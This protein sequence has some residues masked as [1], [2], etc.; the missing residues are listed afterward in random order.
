MRIVRKSLVAAGN[1]KAGAV[2]T[3]EMI[4]IKRPGYG[5]APADME[6]TLGRRVKRD[7]RKDELLTW[8]DVE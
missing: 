2:I 4:A 7:K 1:I 5:I 8:E 6:K 3:Q